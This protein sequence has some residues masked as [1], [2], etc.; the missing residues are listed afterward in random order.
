MFAAKNMFLTGSG[1]AAPTG[2]FFAVEG[3]HFNV[4]PKVY[5]SSD[6]ITWTNIGTVTPCDVTNLG[7]YI[8]SVYANGVLLI[9]ESFLSGNFLQSTN[10][11][12]SFTTTT[13]AFSSGGYPYQPAIDP[14]GT[15]VTFGSDGGD[16]YYSTNSGTTWS[17]ATDGS[18][19][20][21][22]SV[23]VSSKFL[24]ANY[25]ATNFKST[26]YN[27]L[28][29]WSATGQ[30]S[31]TQPYSYVSSACRNILTNRVYASIVGPSAGSLIYTDNAGGSW[32]GASSVSPS[33]SDSYP[34]ANIAASTSGIVVT[35]SG[36]GNYFYVTT[37]YGTTW[38]AVNL[39]YRIWNVVA[40]SGAVFTAATSNGIYSSTDG[41]NWTQR[42]S[43]IVFSTICF[44][45]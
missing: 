30:G 24:H 4:S 1:A 18:T 36:G 23:Y 2:Y 28:T 20:I 7:Y 32:T 22:P 15:Y 45:S 21:Y 33:G 26:A 17:R 19:N 11:G 10:N 35:V 44:G 9:W 38:T 8:N 40:G 5:Q 42:V 41:F 39:G 27:A 14:T 29:S 13:N 43:G 3:V 6:G 37:D 12:A 25:Q 31:F 16:Y 34:T